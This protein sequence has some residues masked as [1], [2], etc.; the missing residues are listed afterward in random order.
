[1]KLQQVVYASKFLNRTP[2]GQSVN[3]LGKMAAGA[4]FDI[5]LGRYRTEGM[6]FEVPKDHTD[7]AMRGKFAVDTYELPERVLVK[8]CLPST[9]SVLELGGCIG[10]V[11]C[12][13]NRH[14]EQPERHI[15]VEGNPSIIPTLTR[16]RDFNRCA[17]QIVHGVVTRRRQP[18]MT[19]C[20]VMD[21][22]QLAGSG[23]EVPAL[24]IERLETTYG[25]Q[26]DALVMDIEGGE[27][28][29]LQEN[30]GLLPNLNAAIIEFHP[31]L[32]GEEKTTQLYQALTD[33]GLAKVDEI[34][35][36]QAWVRL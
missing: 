7:L 10:V 12:V 19:V 1:M 4:Y 35:T 25:L 9:A 30:P 15:V 22:N 5:C 21:S 2:L 6:T 26:F 14:L 17:F 32:L 11:S 23:V 3:L 18:R 29:L 33:A 8:R 24:S 16:N 28:D 13:L 20:S 36:T 31:G 34:L 27:Y